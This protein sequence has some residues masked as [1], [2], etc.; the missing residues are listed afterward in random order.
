MSKYTLPAPLAVDH[1]LDG[2]RSGEDSLDEWLVRR[3][4]VNQVAGFSRTYVITD[5]TRVVGF[6]A[7]SSF[8]ILRSEA[9]PLAGK[10]GPRYLP[11]ILLGRLAVDEKHQ[12]EGLGAALLRH[13]MDLTLAASETVGVRLLVLNALHGQAAAFYRR[14]GFERSPTNP[15]DLMITVKDIKASMKR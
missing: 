14:F 11:A 10:Q 15:L 3:A 5:G 1:L 12:G 4:L 2:F 8:A 9:T 6:H 7:V 13:A